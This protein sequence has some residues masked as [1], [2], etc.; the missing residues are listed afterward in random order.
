VTTQVRDHK[1]RQPHPAAESLSRG[2]VRSSEAEGTARNHTQ[3][4]RRTAAGGSGTPT[5]ETATPCHW[6]TAVGQTKQRWLC[7]VCA[8]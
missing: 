4:P 1:V 7:K 3:A 6:C 5:P 8:L 2:W